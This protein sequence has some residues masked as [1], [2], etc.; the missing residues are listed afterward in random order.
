MADNYEIELLSEERSNL[1]KVAEEHKKQ[2]ISANTKIEKLKHEKE[3]LKTRELFS[4]LNKMRDE[5]DEKSR[6]INKLKKENELL[7]E[8]MENYRKKNGK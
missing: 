6:E 2:L 7:T 8:A 5:V 1:L 3:E 4:R